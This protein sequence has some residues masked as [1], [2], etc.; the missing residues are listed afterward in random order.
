MSQYSK[1]TTP[2]IKLPRN[3]YYYSGRKINKI[4]SIKSVKFNSNKTRFFSIDKYTLEVA[5]R[6]AIEHTYGKNK[7][8]EI[9]KYFPVP[10]IDKENLYILRKENKTGVY[11]ISLIFSNKTNLNVNSYLTSFVSHNPHTRKAIYFSIRKYG[12][13]EAWKRAVDFRYTN[14]DPLPIDDATLKPEWWDMINPIHKT[15]TR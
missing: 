12:L 4:L 2:Q 15:K 9:L 3:I 14:Y 1:N 10:T 6:K 13:E 8:E 5:Y 7:V 11:G